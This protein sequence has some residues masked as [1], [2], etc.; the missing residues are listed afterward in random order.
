MSLSPSR[1]I[2]FNLAMSPG[3]YRSD[4]NRASRAFIQLILPRKVLISP[5]CEI[6]R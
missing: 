3:S 2:G 1:M 6:M 4:A 5:L